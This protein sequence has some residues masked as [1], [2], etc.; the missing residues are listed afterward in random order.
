MP[1]QTSLM[2]KSPEQTAFLGHR[3]ASYLEP[4][5][6][7]VALVEDSALESTLQQFSVDG[8]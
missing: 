5:D 6:T 4:G 3:L 1:D 8:R 2:T 7:V